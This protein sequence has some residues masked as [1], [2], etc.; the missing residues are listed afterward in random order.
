VQRDLATHRRH[1]L[2][3]W[4]LVNGVWFLRIGI[5]LAGLVLAPL[6]IKIDYTGATFISVSFA[7]WLLP[8]ALAELYFRAERSRHA[9]FQNAVGGLLVLLAGLT[10]AG[11]AAAAAFMWWPF[12]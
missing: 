3:A 5:M 10:L 4:L 6:G 1:A 11:A 7:S 9:G 2:R 8:L 12:L